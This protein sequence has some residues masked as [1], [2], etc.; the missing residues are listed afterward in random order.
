MLT[1][2]DLVDEKDNSDLTSLRKFQSFVDTKVGNGIITKS[3]YNNVIS[4]MLKVDVKKRVSV[5]HLL[6]DLDKLNKN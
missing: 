4:K 3:I 2:K 5:S 1:G 6:E